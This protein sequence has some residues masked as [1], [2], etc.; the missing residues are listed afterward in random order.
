[1]AALIATHNL[2]LAHSMHRVLRLEN[3]LLHE[4]RPAD[5]V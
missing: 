2:D 4:T 1:V 3:G 5:V